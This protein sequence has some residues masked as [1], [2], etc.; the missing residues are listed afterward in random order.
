[1]NVKAKVSAT[2]GVKNKWAPLPKTLETLS[3]GH[4]TDVISL[5]CLCSLLIVIFFPQTSIAQCDIGCNASWKW[6]SKAIGVGNQQLKLKCLCYSELIWGW[7]KSSCFTR[8]LKSRWNSCF[9]QKAILKLSSTG[10]TVIL[11]T[12]K[13][14][15]YAAEPRFFPRMHSL[16]RCHTTNWTR[17]KC[18]AWSRA[19]VP[20][21]GF[22]SLLSLRFSL[23]FIAGN[24]ILIVAH[25]SSLEACTCQ[26]QGLSPQ[27]SKDFVQMVRKVIT[28]K[29]PSSLALQKEICNLLNQAEDALFL[30]PDCFARCWAPS[31]FEGVRAKQIGLRGLC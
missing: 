12:E 17:L 24:N 27:N 31:I 5:I 9:L 30:L 14:S 19:A 16:T 29:E 28:S 7:K 11:K 6:K 20:K 15:K 2:E 4:Y 13:C 8:Q 22:V 21:A 3:S 26:L 23:C 18:S 10:L 1:M 25:A